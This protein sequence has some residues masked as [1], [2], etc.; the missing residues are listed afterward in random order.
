MAL[1]GALRGVSESDILF[2]LYATVAAFVLLG[3]TYSLAEAWLAPRCTSI[4][5]VGLFAWCMP[6]GFG[7]PFADFWSNRSFHN[8]RISAT[9]D[10]SVVFVGF[11][12]AAYFA[13]KEHRRTR[14]ISYYCGL[15]SLLVLLTKSFV[16][17]DP[18]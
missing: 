16:L 6:I 13:T 9:F 7:G 1:K 4:R 17:N 5:E 12:V 3:A 8:A 10:W 15:V 18:T 2:A 14:A 11:A